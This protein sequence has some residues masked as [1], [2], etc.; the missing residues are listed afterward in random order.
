[1]KQAR[2]NVSLTFTA[3]AC[4]P[5]S[6]AEAHIIASALTVAVAAICAL[7]A[8]EVQKA[9]GNYGRKDHAL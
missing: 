3:V 5:I 4:L 6:V 1:M 9:S 8:D 2:K 7:G